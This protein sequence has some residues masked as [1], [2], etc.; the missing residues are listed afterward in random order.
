MREQIP[1]RFPQEYIVSWHTLVEL[2]DQ[3]LDYSTPLQNEHL[4]PIFALCKKAATTTKAVATLASMEFWSDAFALSRTLT[5]IEIIV[6]WLMKE[7]TEHRIEKYLSGIEHEK[8]RLLNKMNAGISVTAQTMSDLIDPAE[9][10]TLPPIEDN[11]KGWS[12]LTIR[13]MSREVDMER[14]YDAAYWISSS[15]VHSHAL[16]LLEW[17]PKRDQENEMLVGFFCQHND[18]FQSRIVLSAVP[19]QVLHIFT[20]VDKELGLG[21][22]QKID[23]AW[24]F[25]HLAIAPGKVRFV[26]STESHD[27]GVG[28]VALLTQDGAIVKKYSPKRPVGNK[29]KK[30]KHQSY[31]R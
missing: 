21:F 11:R 31:T 16:S 25:A 12:G 8:R 18:G 1:L 9:L 2:C 27:I 15:I 4:W 6:K 23:A 5:D 30:R 13:E 10:A 24:H 26:N 3:L 20:F 17:N 7:N 29:K 19:M 28:D 14:H 22:G